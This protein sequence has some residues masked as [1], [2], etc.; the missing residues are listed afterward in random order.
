[1]RKIVCFLFA[2]FLFIPMQYAQ[3]RSDDPIVEM[4]DSLDLVRFFKQNDFSSKRADLNIYNFKVDDVPDYSEEEY[5][6]RFEKLD[7]LSPF[8]LQYNPSVKSF[9][10]L[11][12]KK[13]KNLVSRMLGLG[14]LYFPLF[15]EKLAKHNIPLELKH[16]AI[17]ESA[18]NPTATSR[19]GAKGLWQFMYRTGLMYGLHANSYVDERSDPELA[20][21]AACRYLKY[22]HG[23]YNDWNLAL[24]AYNA[25]PGNVNKAIRRAGG[26][27]DYW[28]VRAYL[29]QETQ[30][31]VPAFI[32]VVYVMHYHK[33][34]N[35]FPV[36]PKYFNY[37]IDSVYIKKNI[38]FDQIVNL[39]NVPK[40]D[41]AFLNPM[42]IKGVI[43]GSAKPYPLWLPK[44]YIG[45]FLANED[46]LYVAQMPVSKDTSGQKA[47]EVNVP[48]SIDTGTTRI[49]YVV[50]KGEYISLLAKRYQV[51]VTDIMD[52]NKLSSQTLYVGQKLL[53][54]V[55]NDDLIAAQKE[56]NQVIPVVEQPKLNPTPPPAKYKY[57]TIKS[58]D[59]LYKIASMYKVSVADIMKWNN[60][61]SK[62]IRAGAKLK[63]KV[64]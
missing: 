19:V 34:H 50:K 63:I 10:E 58:G 31:Y 39:I 48:S 6:K 17:V 14:E 49:D 46:K 43:P 28:V 18:L 5:R 62:N 54:Y 12:A 45:D 51:R 22:L 20:T 35:I 24:A 59:T 36:E 64:G 47:I 11:Y 13:R 4:L 7:A 26:S 60:L 55:K 52:W 9:V 21:E 29:P 61:K 40:E 2:C 25:G 32:A 30:N 37:E 38:S 44:K 3:I 23:L 41:L 57:Y 8:S 16:L 56:M 33:E 15:E 1:M 53:L 27:T 42:Y